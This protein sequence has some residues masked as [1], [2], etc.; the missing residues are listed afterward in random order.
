MTATVT[1][2]RLGHVA[3]IRFGRP[4]HNFADVALLKAIAD[5]IEAADADPEVRC[6]V[7]VSEGKVFCGGADLAGDDSVAGEEGMGAIGQF[8]VHAARMFHRAKP[9]VAAVQGA[10]IGAGLGLALAADFRVASPGARFSSNFVRLG[11]HPGFAITRTLKR[12]VG[13]QRAG[14]MMLSAE[15]VKPDAAYAWGLVDRL[16]DEGDAAAE[17]HRMAAEIAANAPLALISVRATWLGGLAD[18]A[19]AATRHEH[20]EQTKL[21]ATEDYAEG[22]ASV[23]ERREANFTGR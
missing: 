10:A 19:V 4:P 11:F 9:M 22:V 1:T 21:K 23:F 14:W 12:V 20:A 8:Y 15:R 13:E 5:A 6:M 2:S 18:E 17:A 7:L 16:A 3:E